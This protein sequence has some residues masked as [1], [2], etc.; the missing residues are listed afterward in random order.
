MEGV[1][2]G[3]RPKAV[4]PSL[5]EGRR[6]DSIMQRYFKHRR[7][8]EGERSALPRRGEAAV[9]RHFLDRRDRSLPAGGMKNACL[10]FQTNLDSSALAKE[11]SS[12]VRS[13]ICS[14]PMGSEFR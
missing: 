1:V 13:F 8:G 6:A 14:T 5:G 7:G 2:F 4:L 3:R 11:G 10:T 9:A 12:R